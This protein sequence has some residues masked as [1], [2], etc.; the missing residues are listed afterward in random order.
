MSLTPSHP[1]STPSA[2][3]IARHREC[4]GC[5]YDLRGLS[6]EG[7]CPE[8]GRPYKRRQ[9]DD[10]PKNPKRQ[11][12]QLEATMRRH[13]RSLKEIVCLWIASFA[14][15]SACLTLKAHNGW[16][17]LALIVTVLAVGS[18]ATLILGRRETRGKIA[19]VESDLAR[20]SAEQRLPLPSRVSETDVAHPSL[21][22]TSSA[23]S[24]L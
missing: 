12:A 14:A 4:T 6:R 21:A 19:A 11:L 13:Q 2:A 23:M 15:L 3:V 9:K 8:C 5:G 18:H 16:W 22:I 20:L 7:V 1:A 17:G 10:V 24:A